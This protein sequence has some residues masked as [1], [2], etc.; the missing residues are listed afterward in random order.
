MTVVERWSPGVS[1]E[2]FKSNPWRVLKKLNNMV[3]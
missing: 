1:K 2:I 3:T